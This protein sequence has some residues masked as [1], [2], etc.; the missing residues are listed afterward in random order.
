MIMMMIT[1]FAMK[2]KKKMEGKEKKGPVKKNN[3]IRKK[4]M[5]IVEIV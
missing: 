4:S 1:I 5:T 3:K 2:M